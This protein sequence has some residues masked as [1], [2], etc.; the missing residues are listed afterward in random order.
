MMRGFRTT[1]LC[2][3]INF[4][5]LSAALGAAAAALAA[6]LVHSRAQTAHALALATQQASAQQQIGVL[7]E[8]LQ[9][10]A[11]AHQALREQLEHWQQ[12]ASAW[13]DQLDARSDEAARLGERAQ[14]ADALQS[15]CEQAQ[16]Q[17]QTLSAQLA[18]VRTAAQA[19]QRHL[20]QQLAL[21]A[22]A[23]SQL[24]DQFKVLAN[25][26]LE[27]KSRRFAE[28]NQTSL[29]ALLDP[30][31]TRLSEFQAK[32]EHAYDVEGKERSALAEQV[33]QLASLNQNLSHDAQALTRAL[34][35][36]AK[37]QGDWGELILERVLEAA[38]LQKDVSYK[39]QESQTRADGSRVRPD[40]VLQLPGE[41]CLVIDAKV[42]LTAFERHAS[43]ESEADRA[44]ALKAHLQ[45]VRA[46]VDELAAKSYQSLYGVQGID[47]VVAFIPIEGAFSLAVGADAELF[48]QAW[49]RNVLLTSPS[50]L[51][52]VVRTVAHLWR[53][54]AQNRNALAI[55]ERGRE[56]YDKFVGF[57]TDLQT[58][59]SRLQLTQQAFDAAQKKLSDGRGN[60]VRQAEMLRDLGVK[61][62]KALPAAL[63]SAAR[64]AEDEAP[65]PATTPVQSAQTAPDYVATEGAAL[66]LT[67]SAAAS[68]T[69]P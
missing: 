22:D 33:R 38:G 37:V 7:N 13:R 57:V 64:E 61:P 8:R 15:Q 69:A 19:E 25:D 63:A 40:V 16:S 53:Q 45:S 5:I 54:E 29:G 3:D 67:G 36:Q 12:Q 46:H 30:L 66:A 14:R 4:L 50:T 52:F 65:N 42:S 28:Q 62:S 44:S 55:A 39:V 35:G 58:L 24:G 59:G 26:I 6:W 32:V 31:R 27:E 21:L 11:L 41:R 51:L 56:L 60:L 23:R 20:A 49:Q 34:K 68:P 17:V 10:Q 18:Q 43:A 1:T 2:M 9:Q 47:F 48:M